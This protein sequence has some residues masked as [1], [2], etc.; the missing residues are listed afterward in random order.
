MRTIKVGK[1]TSYDFNNI[2][3]AINST[4]YDVPVKLLIAEGV[5]EEKIFCE[6]KQIEL[7]GEGTD[8]TIIKWHDGAYELLEYG[9]KRGTF[10]SYTAFLSAENLVVKN[11]SFVNEAGDGRVAGQSVA[12]YSDADVAYFENVCFDSHQDTLFLSPLPETERQ[13]N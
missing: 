3:E 10:R 2:N 1:G 8:K 7:V 4:E 9:E 5:Y 6:K 12:L 11:L 13:K